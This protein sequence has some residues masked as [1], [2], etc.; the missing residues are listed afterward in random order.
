MSEGPRVVGSMGAKAA[1]RRKMNVGDSGS[2]GRR[3]WLSESEGKSAGSQS[4][5]DQRK[6]DAPPSE[7]PRRLDSRPV[8]PRPSPL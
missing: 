5:Q 1:G 3:T 6:A 7:I 8:R 2:L 4:R